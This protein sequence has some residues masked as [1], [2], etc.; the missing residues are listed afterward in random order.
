MKSEQRQTPSCISRRE[1]L[2]AGALL[3]LA[4]AAR[5]QAGVGRIVVGFAPGGAADGLAR[6]TADKLRGIA[7]P[8]VIVENRVGAAARIAIEYVRNAA[9]D[10]TTMTLVPDATMFLYPHVYKSLSY[11]PA[12]DFTPVTRLI[13]M[14]LV[15]F[16]GPAVPS[17]V[18]TVKDYIE[19]VKT[20]PKNLV[21]GTPAAGATPHFTGAMFAR[22]A[23]LDMQ[24]V[25]YKGG[26]PAIQDLVAGQVP[27]VFGSTSDGLAMVQA[28]K[29]RALA[30]SA[31]R[32]TAMLPDV[33]TFQ[34]LGYRD[35][36]VEDGLGVY[37]PSKTPAETVAKLDAGMQAALKTKDLQ[38]PIRDWGF[39]VSGEAPAEFSARLTRERTRWAGVV[40]STGFTAM[41]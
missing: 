2:A 38:G 15:M 29:A 25:H 16:V 3:P 40:K 12:R 34:E 10:G 9:P 17:S 24:P 27:V 37:V 32:R 30:V 19:W 41:E 7:A 26:A 11:D 35:I 8:N 31:A 13:S 5:A 36:V 33:P 14:S 22:A 20:N 39:D 18:K 4:G 1:L 21:Y 28:G 6:L 23:G